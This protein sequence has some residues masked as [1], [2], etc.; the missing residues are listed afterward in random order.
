MYSIQFIKSLCH[1][2]FILKSL[3]L[4]TP[5]FPVLT[6]T[7]PIFTESLGHMR[8]INNKTVSVYP[9]VW[10]KAQSSS[11]LKACSPGVFS[12]QGANLSSF[13]S[14]PDSFFPFPVLSASFLEVLSIWKLLGQEVVFSYLVRG[15]RNLISIFICWQNLRTVCLGVS[16][17]CL[18]DACFTVPL[19]Q[20]ACGYGILGAEMTL[21]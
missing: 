3:S 11:D 21:L 1:L 17:F 19:M 7:Q 10:W 14:L 16:I 15:E 4:H 9:T 13:L 2:W 12:S 6:P 8:K 5:S 18:W 20:Y